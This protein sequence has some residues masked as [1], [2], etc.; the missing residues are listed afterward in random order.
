[1]ENEEK[2]RREFTNSRAVIDKM[3]S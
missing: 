1:M 3:L 2:M